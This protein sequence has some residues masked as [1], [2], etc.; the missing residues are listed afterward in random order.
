MDGFQGYEE[1]QLALV[2]LDLSDLVARVPM[3]LGT[4]TISHVMNVIKEKE[5]DTLA[6]PWVNAQ[7]AYHLVVQWATAIVEDDKVVAVGSNP[8]DYDEAVIT[9]DMETTDAFLSCIICVKTETAYTGMGLNVM[10]QALC[11]KDG[12]L[13]QVLTIQNAY[14]ELHMGNKNVTV[15]VR[16]SMSYPQTLWKKTL[17]ARAVVATCLSK[18][19]MQTGMMEVSGKA[20]GLQML[21]LSVKQRQ[22]KLF[23][24]LDFS[25]L[26][27]W[28]PWLADSTQ[29]LLAEYHDVFALDPGELGCTHSTKCVINVTNN[30]PF[31]EQ[32]RQIPP[33]LVE[34][35]CTHLWEMLDSGAI[36]PS[37]SAW[38]NM[39]VLVWKK[40]G[41]LH[42]C[43]DFHHLNA[44]M[45]KTPTHCWTSKKHWRV[46]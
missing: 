41:S 21:K 32:F 38:C 26:E 8:T 10:T 17:V 39:V 20:Q 2:I 44:H 3:I 36:H 11:A 19:P 4:P 1:D 22:E 13:P 29:S 37:Q 7:M 24:E 33:P 31:K 40:D 34:E 14:T 18:L 25:R 27:S 5:I 35:V 16:N 45:K 42:F 6:T 12:S 43:I 23:K 46:W 15:V 9:K 30:T 28:P